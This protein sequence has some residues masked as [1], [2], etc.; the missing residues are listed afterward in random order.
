[1]L[2]LQRTLIGCIVRP[3]TIDPSSIAIGFCTMSLIAFTVHLRVACVVRR[4]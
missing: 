3:V 1:M 4:P 2:F